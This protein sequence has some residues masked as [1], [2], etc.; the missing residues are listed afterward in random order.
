MKT[1]V[2]EWRQLLMNE[3]DCYW[4]K[5]LLMNEDDSY[6]MKKTL[7][8]LRL[9]I[10]NEDDYYWINKTVI[11]IQCAFMAVRTLPWMTILCDPECNTSVIQGSVQNAWLGV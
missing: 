9:L 3:D 8:D 2:I 5:K 4:M 11:S 6:W 1:T 10:L 7:I